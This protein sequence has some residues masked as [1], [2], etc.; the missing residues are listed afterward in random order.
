MVWSMWDRSSIGRLCK[1]G[2]SAKT[3][4]RVVTFLASLANVVRFISQKSPFG[5]RDI[6]V[7]VQFKYRPMCTR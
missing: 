3:T 4:V 6:I 1:A 5:Q 7:C 2:S